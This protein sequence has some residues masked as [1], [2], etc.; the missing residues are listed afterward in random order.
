MAWKSY[1][2]D[3]CAQ[4]LVLN[5]RNTEVLNETHKMRMT[6]A[7]GLERF[8]GERFRL[9]KNNKAKAEYWQAT[10]E[11]LVKIMGTAKLKIPNDPIDIP[12]DWKNEEEN[13]RYT[14]QLQ[15]MADKLWKLDDRQESDNGE[16]F[17]QTRRK[18]A[19]AVLTQLCDCM[20][21]WAQRYKK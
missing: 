21:W 17:N 5:H 18:V 2:L 4:R 3:E 20:V 15:E 19:L 6:V 9:E 11:E 1:K 10:W 13:V 7:Y 14:R 16:N 8:W 12:N